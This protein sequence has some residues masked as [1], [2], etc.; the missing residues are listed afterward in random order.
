MPAL[1]DDSIVA[2][3]GDAAR[4][5]H[6][7]QPL[8]QSILSGLRAIAL[9]RDEAQRHRMA[10]AAEIRAGTIS[11]IARDVIRVAIFALA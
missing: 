1:D 10:E 9:T 11:A 2:M 7:G 4:A 3:A 8:P 6:D 5:V